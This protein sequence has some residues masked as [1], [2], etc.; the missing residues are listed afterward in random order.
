MIIPCLR[1]VSVAAI[2]GVSACVTLPEPAAVPRS[3]VAVAAPL[4]ATWESVLEQLAVQGIAVRTV[5]TSAGFI[6]TET[7]ALPMFTTDPHRW[8]NCG[9]FAGFAFAPSAVD[10]TVFVR[11]DEGASSLKASARYRLLKTDGELPVDC[12]STG[13]FEESFGA[14]VRRRAEAGRP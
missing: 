3:P 4:A 14:A 8:A 1:F 7:V 13:A 9:T 6:A 11:G 5:E 12:V 10:Y 2:V